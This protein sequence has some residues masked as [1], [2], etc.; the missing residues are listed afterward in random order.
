MVSPTETHRLAGAWLIVPTLLICTGCSGEAWDWF[1]E[2]PTATTRPAGT[3]DRA[4]LRSRTPSTPA[5]EGTIGSVA[6]VQGIKMMRVRGFGLVIGLGDKGSR[7]CRPSVRDQVIRDLRRYRSANPHATRE[8][9]TAEK[10]LESLD[11]AVVEVLA[12]IPA[13]ALR[14]QH[15][16]VYVRADDEDTQSLAGGYLIPCDLRIF[17]EVSQEEGIEG[18]IHARAAGPIF[19]NPFAGTS[20]RSEPLLAPASRPAGGTDANV[21]EGWIIGGGLNGTDRR[22]SLVATIESYATVRQIQD[23]INRRFTAETKVADAVSPT[24]VDLKIPPEFRNRRQYF[25]DLV[26][27]L[28]L[29]NSATTREGRAKALIGELGRPGAPLDDVGLSLEGLGPSIVPLVQPFYTEPRKQV[30]FYAGRTGTRLGDTLGLEV[31]IQHAK[32]PRSAYRLAAVKELGQITATS[33]TARAASALRE[34][35]AGDDAR[36]RILAYESLR[37]IDPTSMDRTIVGERPQNFMLEIVPCDGPLVVYARR[38][39]E[40]R[41]ALIGG[42]RML[43]QPPLLYS[44]AAQPISLTARAD[45][46]VVTMFR[47][48]VGGRTLGPIPG[49]LAVPTV[50]R[51]LGNNLRTDLE[52]RLKGFGLDYAIVLDVLYRLCEKGGINAEMRWEEPSVE[53]LVGPLEPMGR[54]ESEL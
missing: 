9:P 27:H 17:Q 19:V 4:E 36:M 30:S 23:S 49:P 43:F 5:L 39:E 33:M 16:D 47:K 20:S 21:R 12:D 1:R 45:D 3:L 8:L 13:G 6:Y 29:S 18:R 38:T 11:T 34:L 51:F 24:N 28:P 53:D 44:Q 7:N 31:L 25:L 10:Q 52:G 26:M 41:L 54:P 42:D 37:R 2:K 22:L 15:F 40:R 46:K 48:E 14:D 35:L 50:V 32:N